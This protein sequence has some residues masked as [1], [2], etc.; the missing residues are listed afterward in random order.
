MSWISP[1][2]QQTSAMSTCEPLEGIIAQDFQKK[3]RNQ[4]KSIM[5]KTS[6]FL[7]AEKKRTKE[8]NMLK[9]QA[10]YEKKKNAC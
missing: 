10:L 1:P 7:K 5:K 6:I 3:D 2:P 9:T 8:Q 4:H